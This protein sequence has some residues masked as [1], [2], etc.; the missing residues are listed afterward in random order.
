MR[1][2]FD[3]RPFFLL[4]IFTAA[5]A[6]LSATFIDKQNSTVSDFDNYVAQFIDDLV[7]DESGILVLHDRNSDHA[8]KKELKHF[9]AK[10]NYLPVWSRE[11]RMLPLAND[12]INT[13]KE[14]S[15]EGLYP[16]NPDYHLQ[17]LQRQLDSGYQHD[18]RSVAISDILLSD[19]FFTLGHHLYSGIAAGMDLNQTRKIRYKKINMGRILYKAI[20]SN[21]LEESLINLSPKHPV[22]LDLKEELAR[23]RSIESEGGW[24][25]D[26]NVYLKMRDVTYRRSDSKIKMETITIKEYEALRYAVE[27][28][29]KTIKER[30]IAT[31]D[32]AEGD[33]L[34]DAIIRFQERHGI[35]AD[36]I[37]GSKTASKMAIPV[38]KK[39]EKILLNMERWRWLPRKIPSN[40]LMVNIPNFTLRAIENDRQVFTMPVVVGKKS[41]KT[42]AFSAKMEYMV[43]NPYWR[44]PKSILRK[45]I[46]PKVQRDIDY[47]EQKNIKIFSRSDVNERHPID[48][49]D[50]DWQNWEDEEAG[51][52][53]FRQEPGVKNA[54]GNVKFIFPNTFD[55]YIHDTPSKAEFSNGKNLSSSG[56]IRINNPVKLASHLMK[57][58]FSNITPQDI[59]TALS[60]KKTHKVTLSRPMP[61][62]ITYQTAWS[63]EKGLLNFRRDIY[64]YDTELA[65]H[66]KGNH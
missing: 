11:L 64:Q 18:I 16:K 48:P 21:R 32:F 63:D 20:K 17:T 45:D 65:N 37:V 1:I 26:P 43:F 54:L 58:D 60:D 36:G 31:D 27:N 23:Y 12:M 9:Y 30:L 62:Y 8:I 35:A 46:V 10:R 7:N 44:I 57:N 29:E 33:T 4:L 52:Y 3:L 38:E 41:R 34:T 47:L 66:L 56:C 22:F 13:I 15:K 28:A 55:I 59:S 49:Y 42:P 51:R 53:R 40:Y 14:I 61:V 2:V 19:A 25:N 39:I 5:P 24:Q 6:V 50:I